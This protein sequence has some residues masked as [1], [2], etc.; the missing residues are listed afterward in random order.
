MQ[1]SPCSTW[2]FKVAS[3][4]RFPLSYFLASFYLNQSLKLHLFFV[5]FSTTCVARALCQTLMQK[6]YLPPFFSAFWPV[7]EPVPIILFKR[8]IR[9]SL[10]SWLMAEAPLFTIISPNWIQALYPSCSAK[11]FGASFCPLLH[12][13]DFRS[14]FASLR[15][16]EPSQKTFKT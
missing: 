12:H 9:K 6:P 10:S 8:A 2:Q 15:M 16:H 5:N 11:L 4:N 14:Y 13:T 3:W 1:L 7:P